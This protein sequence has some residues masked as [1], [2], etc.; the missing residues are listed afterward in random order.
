M[1]ISIKKSRTASFNAVGIQRMAASVLKILLLSAVVYGMVGF[2]CTY[3]YAEENEAQK[4]VLEEQSGS[5]ETAKIKDQIKKQLSQETREIMPEF[6]PEKIIGDVSKGSFDFSISGLM[7]RI[8]RFLFKEFYLNINILIKLIV[9]VI[10]CSILKNLQTSFLSESVGELAF[11]ACYIV[12]VSIL[13]VS[14]NTALNM[15]KDIIDNMVAFMHATIPAMITLLVS[16]G[17]ITSGAVFQPILIMIVEIAATVMKNF[18]IPLIFLY[19]TLSVINNISDKIQISKLALFLKQIGTWGLGLMLTVFVAIVTIQGTAGAVVDGVTGK[20][21]KFAIGAFIPVA[22]KY[23]ADAADTVVGC[24]LLIKNA[25][26][27]AVM[28]G[29]VAVCLVPILKIFAMV[30]LYRVTCVLIEPIAE[31]RITGC[32]ND[33]AN[34]LT[35]VLGIVASVAFMFLI[36]ITAIITAGGISAAVR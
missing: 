36:T 8:L 2:S 24:T 26:G 30:V 16:G 15:G 18:F 9:L 13:L 32:I 6:D 28:L 25:A 29:I 7:K 31:K 14:F 1:Y 3:V 35:F 4:R 5:D 27:I 23:L 11:Y 22:G 12:I 34:S 33:I 17:N 19:A 21:A 10:L 20:T